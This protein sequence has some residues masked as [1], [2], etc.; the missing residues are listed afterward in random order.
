MRYANTAER[1]RIQ[2]LNICD[3]LTQRIPNRGRFGGAKK[4]G[5]SFSFFDAKKKID[6]SRVWETSIR[7]CCEFFYRGSIAAIS[8]FSNRRAKSLAK[9]EIEKDFEKSLGAIFIGDIA[10]VFRCSIVSTLLNRQRFANGSATTIHAEIIRI[11]IVKSSRSIG[12]FN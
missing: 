8:F 6:Y 9:I 11:Q 1:N 7:S 10:C 2:I 4:N 12:C 3:Q 5:R